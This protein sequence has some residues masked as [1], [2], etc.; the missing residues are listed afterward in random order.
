L[1]YPSDKTSQSILL[2]L[3][4]ASSAPL[5]WVYRLD[6]EFKTQRR[7]AEDAE[8]TEKCKRNL[9]QFDLSES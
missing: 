2:L 1:P 4:S 9:V 8:D 3:S 6:S 7:G 5:R